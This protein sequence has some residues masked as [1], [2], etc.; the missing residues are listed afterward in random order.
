MQHQERECPQC[1]EL[2]TGRADKQFCSE[3]CKAQNR[4]NNLDSKF[5][6]DDDKDDDD[7]ADDDTDDEDWDAENDDWDDEEDDEDE[8]E[9]P[10]I[11]LH[12]WA[13]G[14]NNS[15]SYIV[16]LDQASEEER[17]R[18]YASEFA[19]L[20]QLRLDAQLL[21]EASEEARKEVEAIKEKSREEVEATKTTHNLYSTLIRKC[22]KQD[23]QQLDEVD[24]ETWVE[25]LDEACD[26]Y[27]TNPALR[28]PDDKSHKRLKDLYWLRDMFSS[29]LAELREQQNS[30]FKQVEPVFLSLPLKRKA[31]FRDNLIA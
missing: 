14:V 7:V 2:Y 1:G 31:R 23:G 16:R 24:L 20:K 13:D 17:D 26:K 10:N 25:E 15:P 9:K 4:R 12:K 3:A 6:D 5:T 28:Q 8:G 22:L 30:F 27:L 18:Y 21:H 19:R 29:D 11:P